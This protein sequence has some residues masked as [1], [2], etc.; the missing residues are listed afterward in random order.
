MYITYF[1]VVIMFGWFCISSHKTPILF[2]YPFPSATQLYPSQISVFYQR[3]FSFQRYIMHIQTNKCKYVCPPYLFT[4]LV[5]YYNYCPLSSFF[6]WN[7]LG[8]HS[9]LA[10]RKLPCS[11]L[12]PHGVPLYRQAE[13]YTV[14]CL[15]AFNLFLV[16][17][18]CNRCYKQN[19]NIYHFGHVRLYL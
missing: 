11:F 7:V 3:H 1:C 10:Q 12:Q 14:S 9:G 15:W 4:W 18:F 19:L 13:C 8:D 16:H 17:Y 2:P 5:A 6:S